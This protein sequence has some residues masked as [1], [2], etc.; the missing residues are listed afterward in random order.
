[1]P[2]VITQFPHSDS[3]SSP[4][5]FHTVPHTHSSQSSSQFFTQFY[6]YFLSFPQFLTIPHTF[7]QIPSHSFHLRSAHTSSKVVSHTDPTQ[8]SHSSTLLPSVSYNSTHMTSQSLQVCYSSPCI[9]PKF[10]TIPQTVPQKVPH[11]FFTHFLSQFHTVPHI[12][13][14]SHSSHAFPHNSPQ[15]PT[16]FYT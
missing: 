15:F 3:R 9:S 8:F 6:T 10:L 7:P 11:K 1:M 16:Q 4:T 2:H 14:T 13:H 5:P 12:V